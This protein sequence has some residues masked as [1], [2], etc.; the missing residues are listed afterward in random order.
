MTP[1]DIALCIVG[2]LALIAATQVRMHSSY[3]PF[4]GKTREHARNCP[5]RRND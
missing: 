5:K 2:M 1:H 4:C 3:C